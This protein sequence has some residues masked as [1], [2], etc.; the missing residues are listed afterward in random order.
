MNIEVTAPNLAKAAVGYVSILF[1]DFF[2]LIIASSIFNGHKALSRDL[3]KNSPGW[4][5]TKIALSMKTYALLLSVTASCVETQRN[6]EAVGVGSVVGLLIFGSYNVTTVL[7]DV[8]WGW[9]SAVADTL[10]GTASCG[11]LF[12]ILF[13]V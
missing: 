13:Y 6:V 7:V 4:T 8:R 9:Q 10:Y 5:Y 11:L 1:L 3:F 12:L 2:Y